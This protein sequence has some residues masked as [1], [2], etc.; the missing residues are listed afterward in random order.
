MEH[1]MIDIETLATGPN[2]AIATIAAVK[3]D[4]HS[5]DT[6]AQL[7]LRIDHQSNKELKRAID[8][9]TVYWWLGQDPEAKFDT[10]MHKDRVPLEEAL[11]KLGGF[12]QSEENNPKIWAN[13]PRFDLAILGHAYQSLDIKVP[14]QFWQERDVRTIASLNGIIKHSTE[15]TGAH[16]ALS[17]CYHQIN[18]CSKVIQSLFLMD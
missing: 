1:I 14:W 9:D 5:G 2:A 12:V 3:F 16:H 15:N 11:I 8:P 18:Y 7:Y 10:F 4:F 13:S 17:D 6:G